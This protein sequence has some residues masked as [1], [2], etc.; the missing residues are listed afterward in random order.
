MTSPAVIRP[1]VARH[2]APDLRIIHSPSTAGLAERVP[3]VARSGRGLYRPA[4]RTRRALRQA[5][6]A[7]RD[8]S[9]PQDHRERRHRPSPPQRRRHLDEAVR[10][11]HPP[12]LRGLASR[13]PVALTYPST[14]IETTGP[15]STPP[16][17]R[18]WAP[19]AQPP[20]GRPGSRRGSLASAPPLISS[21]KRI[22]NRIVNAP[23]LPDMSPATRIACSFSTRA[24]LVI[25]IVSAL[26]RPEVHRWSCRRMY[27]KSSSGSEFG[28][29]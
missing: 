23:Q 4:P 25:R 24:A 12:P 11:L 5:Q 3:S 10:S 26:C 29:A 20:A 13:R 21:L 15:A 1:I 22:A 16:G 7:R 9:V 27:S 14:L 8:D 19:R 6:G 2:R 18:P 28:G 17:P